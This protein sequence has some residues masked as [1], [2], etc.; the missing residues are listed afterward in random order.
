[1]KITTRHYS[2]FICCALYLA[3]SAIFVSGFFLLYQHL[4]Q[5]L[6]S[7]ILD[8]IA[9][10]IVFLVSLAYNNTSM[11]D[12]YWSVMPLPIILCW[13]LS[14]K[15]AT[16]CPVRQYCI[17]ALIIIWSFRLTYNWLRRWKGLNDED[18]RYSAYRSLSKTKFWLI[19]LLGFHLFPT[20]IVF[21]GC[22][23]IFPA[24]VLISNPFNTT[25][26]IATCITLSGILI[27][28]IADKQLSSFKQNQS[29]QRIL[30]AGLW[31]YIR[32]PNYLGEIT[33]WTGLCIFSFSGSQFFWY[34]LPG[35]GFIILMFTFISA[36]M[37]DR[38]LSARYTGYDAYIKNTY[39]IFPWLKIK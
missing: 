38:R 6:L 32:H 29:H 27:E 31:K 11:Y 10:F 2:V 34:V 13:L 1:M 4:N 28:W 12:P 36:P 37:M 14:S 24:I 15:P 22:L 5:L 7:F 33:F 35:P 23:S 20:L 9:T 19:S 3:V 25:D 30:S 21:L 39:S 16:V 18:W 17:L 26:F 8:L